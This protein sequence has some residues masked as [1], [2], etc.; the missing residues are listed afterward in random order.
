M[1]ADDLVVVAK[2]FMLLTL[3]LYLTLR[4]DYL[5]ILFGEINVPY[6]LVC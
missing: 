6:I 2:L 3:T 5:R 1:C 4:L